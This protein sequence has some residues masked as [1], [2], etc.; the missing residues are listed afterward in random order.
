MVEI[1]NFVVMLGQVMG[2]FGE[3]WEM[4]PLTSD[5]AQNYPKISKIFIDGNS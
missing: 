5:S 3:L 4:P 1:P 2:N